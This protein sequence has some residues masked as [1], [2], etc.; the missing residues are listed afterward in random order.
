MPIPMAM[1]Y[2]MDGKLLTALIPL[3]VAMVMQTPMAMV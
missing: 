1:A 3:M 2:P